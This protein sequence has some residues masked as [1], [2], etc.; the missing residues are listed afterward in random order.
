MIE[1][2]R[3]THGDPDTKVRAWAAKLAESER[4]RD[5]YQEMFAAEAM[6]LNELNGSYRMKAAR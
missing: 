4:K 3:K 1:R 2:E 5:G 6:T